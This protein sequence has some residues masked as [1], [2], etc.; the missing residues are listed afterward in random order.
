MSQYVHTLY[1]LKF[2]LNPKTI[3]RKLKGESSNITEIPPKEDV[4]SFWRNIWGK[5]TM[6]NDQATWLTTLRSEYC[7]DVIQNEYIINSNV[8]DNMINKLQNG[9]APGNDMIVEY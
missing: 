4:E 1:I 2:A 6:H 3:Y 5:H 8:L 9:K 7:Q